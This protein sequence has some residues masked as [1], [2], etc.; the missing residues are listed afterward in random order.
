MKKGLILVAVVILLGVVYMQVAKNTDQDSTPAQETEMQED[1]AMMDDKMEGNT[2][3]AMMQE[4]GTYNV[5]SDSSVSYVVQ[6]EWFSKPAETVVG[7]SN[8][9]QGSVKYDATTQVLESIDIKLNTESLS[10]GSDGRDKEVV[11][12]LGSEIIISTASAM[13]G[14]APGEV[15]RTIPLDVTINGQT[16][17]VDFDVTG[18]VS[19]TMID[20]KGTAS[21]NVADFGI[22]TP[23]LLG[24]Y[25]VAEAMNLNFE[26]KATK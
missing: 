19:D 20:V 7:T 21:A 11:Q 26:L 12:W 13:E 18:T 10:S 1:A 6:K 25:T 4:E 24:V 3:D 2:G 22:E 9:I 17:T 23:S 16:N 15:S 14:I 8:E 5:Q